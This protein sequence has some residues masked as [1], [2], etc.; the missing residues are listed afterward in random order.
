VA[1][2]FRCGDQLLFLGFYEHFGLHFFVMTMSV[3]LFK[4]KNV[5]RMCAQNFNEIRKNKEYKDDGTFE[6]REEI[7]P[8]G[9]FDSPVTTK[10]PTYHLVEAENGEVSLREN[11]YNRYIT[12]KN[13]ATI[14]HQ[15]LKV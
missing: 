1:K 6:V 4:S 13:G 9:Y 8:R 5:V 3:S 14:M 15:P 10:L 2:S 11:S 12:R 7:D